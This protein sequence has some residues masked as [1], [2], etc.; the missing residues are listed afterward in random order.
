MLTQWYIVLTMSQQLDGDAVVRVPREW[1]EELKII[2]KA[3]D[4]M[5]TWG[6]KVR[7]IIRG[8]LDMRAANAEMMVKAAQ[9]EAQ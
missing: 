7:E 9:A 5:K 2:A 8:Y 1:A 3:E 6:A 4:P